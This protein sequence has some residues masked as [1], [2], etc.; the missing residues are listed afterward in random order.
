M[1][2]CIKTFEFTLFWREAQEDTGRPRQYFQR[3][4]KGEEGNFILGI[5]DQM[6]QSHQARED[7]RKN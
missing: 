6:Q 4:Q 3:Q 7:R 1:K 5:A 2:E